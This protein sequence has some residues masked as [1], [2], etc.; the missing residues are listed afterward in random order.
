MRMQ[1]LKTPKV[2]EKQLVFADYVSVYEPGLETNQINS[3]KSGEMQV[4]REALFQRIQKQREEVVQLVAQ[5]VKKPAGDL[6][7]VRLR[8]AAAY[9]QAC[10]NY[11]ELINED[12]KFVA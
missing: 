6:I 10:V 4:N 9:K 1:M 2:I 8:A 7:D 11:S 5:R 3:A 12:D